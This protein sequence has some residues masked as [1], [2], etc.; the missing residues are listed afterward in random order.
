MQS[1]I[2]LLSVIPCRREPSS[3]SEMV[4]Q[5][6]F[7]ESY[8][9]LEMRDDWISIR[10]ASDG[11][12]CWISARQHSPLSEK[13]WKKLQ[14]ASTALCT[15]LF[16]IMQDKSGSRTFPVTLGCSLPSLSNS[17]T[18]FEIDGRT[19][20]FEGQHSI[21]HKKRNR[22]ELLATA[23][24]LLNAPYLWGGRNPLGIDCSGFTQLVF[25]LGGYALPRDAY[26]QA[27]VGDTVDFVEEAL[28]GDLAFFDNAEGKIT[29]T[30][31][32]LGQ[33]RIIHASG[34]V[35]IDRF[36]HYGIH[37][38]EIKKYTHSLRIIKRILKH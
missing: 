24:L 13:A 5:L 35:R 29:H 26:Q 25:R 1:G 11:Y 19:Y 34:C 3:T 6:L 14:A 21:P 17:S 36:D 20:S 4:T 2:C 28:P 27:N 22:D 33:N 12:E 23:Y 8:E 38:E 16:S 32:L 37:H 18:A 7:G 9:V 15:D 30:G 31:I 10:H